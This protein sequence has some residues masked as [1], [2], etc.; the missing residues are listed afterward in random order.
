MNKRVR[1]LVEWLGREQ[2]GAMDRGRRREALEKTLR[3]H[4]APGESMTVDSDGTV[5]S[6]LSGGAAATMK[7]MEELMEELIGFQERFGPGAKIS[8]ERGRRIVSG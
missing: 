4:A 6:H 5:G 7:Q 2:A 3:E 1:A 8:N